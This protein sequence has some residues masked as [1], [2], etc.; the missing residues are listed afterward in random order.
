MRGIPSIPKGASVVGWLWCK[1]A[2][3]AQRG[4][5]RTPIPTTRTASPSWHRNGRRARSRARLVLRC[6]P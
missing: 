4:W 5:Y 3:R 1:T 6:P 2:G